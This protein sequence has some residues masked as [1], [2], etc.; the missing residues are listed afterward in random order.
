[1]GL[2]DFLFGQDPRD[3]Q[4]DDPDL[5]QARRT[6][7]LLRQRYE[8]QLSGG[9]TAG[10]AAIMEA[11]RTSAEQLGEA[12]Q[13]RAAG[14]RGFGRLAAQAGAERSA[15]VGKQRLLGQAATAAG[16]QRAQ[17]V[18]QAESQMLRLDQ[19]ALEQK[20]I[21]DEERRRLAK[22]GA[23]GIAGALAGGGIGGFFGGPEGAMQG[24][25]LGGTLGGGI[26]QFGQRL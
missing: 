25:Q 23:L 19:M 11:A 14:A 21:E 6:R 7:D 8:Q 15:M 22:P 4:L 9:Q 12:A 18:A 17:D 5:L 13:G 3:V 20:R 26:S 16:A 24:A 1:M 10:E 2:G